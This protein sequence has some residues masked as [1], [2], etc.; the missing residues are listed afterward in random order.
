MARG[1]GPASLQIHERILGSNE[2]TQRP[3][4]LIMG[5]SF[6]KKHAIGAYDNDPLVHSLLS[7]LS[8]QK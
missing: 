3:S 4:H 8:S 1:G 2:C 7:P 5:I 6:W